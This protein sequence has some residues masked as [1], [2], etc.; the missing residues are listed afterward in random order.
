VFVF[1]GPA[2]YVSPVALRTRLATG[3]PLSLNLSTVVGRAARELRD[4]SVGVDRRH[5]ADG[6][7]LVERLMRQAGLEGV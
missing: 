5:R 4:A 1:G 7:V 6:L 2:G 3:V